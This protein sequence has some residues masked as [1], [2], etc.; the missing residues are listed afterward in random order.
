MALATFRNFFA[1]RF[2]SKRRTLQN[3]SS[4][5]FLFSGKPVL[6]YSSI[7]SLYAGPPKSAT[8]KRGIKATAATTVVEPIH[9]PK[10]GIRTNSPV[11]TTRHNGERNSHIV[12]LPRFF[13]YDFVPLRTSISSVLVT[14]PSKFSST[15]YLP[16]SCGTN[17]LE[18][19]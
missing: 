1:H 7:Y 5:S 13:V 6:F 11:P 14:I 2:D 4:S 16:G 19:R 10:P 18:V 9:V 17:S 3:L 8:K 15:T 12:A